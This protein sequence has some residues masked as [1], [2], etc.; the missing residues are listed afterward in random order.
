MNSEK[1]AKELLK[2]FEQLG[3]ILR[4]FNQNLLQIQIWKQRKDREQ[5]SEGALGHSTQSPWRPATPT[6]TSARKGKPGM[7]P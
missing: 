3:E 7:P 6:E 2:Q 4:N 5:T 1:P